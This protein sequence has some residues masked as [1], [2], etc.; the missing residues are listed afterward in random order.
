[1]TNDEYDFDGDAWID[2]CVLTKLRKITIT[3]V[4]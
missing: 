1:M 4:K 2:T 3:L